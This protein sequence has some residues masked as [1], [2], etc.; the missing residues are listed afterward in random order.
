MV[1][2][3]LYWAFFMADYSCGKV[4]SDFEII[5]FS[6]VSGHFVADMLFMWYHGFLDFGNFL[7]HFMG[8][9]VYVQLFYF[10]HNFNQLVLHL[11]AA[12]ITNVNMH[13]R[14]VYR[15]MGWRYTWLYYVNEYQYSFMY[16]TIRALVIPALFY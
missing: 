2:V 16:M 10:Q 1:V 6:S 13:I 5:I 8:I 4:N 3:P 14:E 15:R 12:E 7:H 9:F 11:L